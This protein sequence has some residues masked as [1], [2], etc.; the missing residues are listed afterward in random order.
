MRVVRGDFDACQRLDDAVRALQQV[1]VAHA[2]ALQDALMPAYTHLQRAQPVEVGRGPF[3]ARLEDATEEPLL[4][5]AVRADVHGHRRE[6]GHQ[7][8][9]DRVGVEP[10]VGV[11]VLDREARGRPERDEDAP[12]RALPSR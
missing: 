7:L 9:V 8:G 3:A 10:G 4:L 5:R 11:E 1:M 6:S 2:E 12:E